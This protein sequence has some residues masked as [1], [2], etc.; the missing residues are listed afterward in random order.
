MADT[1]G[2]LAAMNAA[3]AGETPDEPVTTVEDTGTGEDATGD[4]AGGLPEGGDSD[5]TGGADGAH[6]DGES[7]GEDAGEGEPA[8]KDGETNI[9]AEAAELGVSVKRANGQ[10]KS[11][12]ELATDVAAAKAAKGGEP[13]AGKDAAAGK[14]AKKEPDPV[15][16]PIPKDLKPETQQRIR[17]LIERAKGSEEKAT[18]A[19]Q[20]FNYMIDGVKATGTTP[21]QYGE[22]LSFMALF[23][24]GDPKQQE[25]ALGLLED[26][27]DRLATLLGKERQ[28]LDPLAAHQD[29]KTAL[30]GGQITKQFAI[31]TARL[32]NQGAFR[33]QLNTQA[34][35]DQQQR[36][37]QEREVQQVRG[38]LDQLEVHLRATDPQYEQKKAAIL[39]TLRAVLPQ[40]PPRQRKDAFMRVYNEARF[41]PAPKIVPKPAVPGNQPLRANKGGSA[42]GGS[43]KMNEAGPKSALDAVNAALASIGK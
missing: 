43:G 2:A 10:F 32:R 1:A 34:Q 7:G 24:S 9:A 28:V 11:K 8:G 37:A 5:A 27:A 4:D 36:E 18:K 6:P 17:T 21:E 31:E 39:P 40:L 25:T 26:M 22:V 13:G 16:D 23:N 12:E 3:L 20:D 19:E 33:Q 41:T 15:N 14:A 38:E 35:T 42:A 30:Q 29:L